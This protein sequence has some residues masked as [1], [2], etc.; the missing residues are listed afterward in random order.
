[1]HFAYLQLPHVTKW[2]GCLVKVEALSGFWGAGTAKREKR[3]GGKT[4]A[5][6]ERKMREGST[7]G[8]S[9][10]ISSS[11]TATMTMTCTVGSVSLRGKTFWYWKISSKCSE[12]NKCF[13]PHLASALPRYQSQLRQD[14]SQ[15][16]QAP[17]SNCAKH[18]KSGL[19][20]HPE[21]SQVNEISHR[22]IQ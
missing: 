1:M 8:S 14:P 2:R 15:E 4:M 12:T 6:Q 21:H 7:S 13:Y 9:S 19:H 16:K 10:I 22:H 18:R 17:P 11:H 20:F 3:W 5:T